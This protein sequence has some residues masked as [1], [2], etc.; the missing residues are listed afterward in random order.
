MY[1]SLR[2]DIKENAPGFFRNGSLGSKPCTLISSQGCFGTFK[3]FGVL[4][5]EISN[6]FF[7]SFVFQFAV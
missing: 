2:S 1:L 7:L 3:S 4:N 5:A 6:F